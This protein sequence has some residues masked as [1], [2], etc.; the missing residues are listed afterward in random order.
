VE[1]VEKMKR[2]LNSK[3]VR[4]SEATHHTAIS[5]AGRLKIPITE[6][7]DRAIDALEREMFFSQMHSV[8]EQLADDGKLEE[9]KQEIADWDATLS[10]GL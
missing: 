1:A 4:V 6:V 5:I 8:Y 7:F 9:F 10:D 2:F 3:P